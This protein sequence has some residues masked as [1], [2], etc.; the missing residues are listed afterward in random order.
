MQGN[1]KGSFRTEDSTNVREIE[2]T[3]CAPNLEHKPSCFGK[4]K[5]SYQRHSLDDSYNQA[6]GYDEVAVVLGKRVL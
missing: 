6:R 5:L 2:G 4:A 1:N 3:L